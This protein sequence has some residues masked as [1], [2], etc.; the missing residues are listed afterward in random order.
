MAFAEIVKSINPAAWI[1][2]T[3][4]HVVLFVSLVVATPF[5]MLQ[6]YMQDA[7]HLL[8]VLKV[9]LWGL[10]IVVVPAI[11]IISII[12]ALVLFRRYLTKIRLLGALVAFLMI[13]SA[14]QVADLYLNLKFYDIQQNWHYF[15]YA[16]FAYILYRDL[17]PRGVSWDKLIRYAYIIALSASIFDEAF[18]MEMS[19]RIFD[20]S[21]IAKDGWGV[22][23]GLLLIC[24]WVDKSFFLSPEYRRLR[25]SRLRDYFVQP[26]SLLLLLMVM[27]FLLIF[28]SSLLTE[29]EYWKH[30]VA[31]TLLTSAVLLLLVHISQFKWGK[32]SLIVVLSTLI[33]IQLG[34][35]IKYRDQGIT[36][37][38]A[39]LT[40]YKGIP[41]PFFDVMFYPDGRIRLVDKKRS[42]NQTDRLFLLRQESDI[43]L[44]GSGP[45]GEGGEGFP[46]KADSQFLYNPISKKGT[47][48]IVL[49]NEEACEVFN[50]LIREKK[51]VLFILHNPC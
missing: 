1:N 42:F 12:A 46:K 40:I 41:L 24:F 13:A 9:E 29:L 15:A 51:N 27:T 6:V 3:R 19:N 37:T 32:M 35:F 22:L 25:H 38:Q 45:D 21:D 2:S 28:Y 10:E 31:F 4:V 36:H 48:V 33:L 14:Q 11:A 47:Q 34:S 5:M 39:G 23:M 20:I 16:L 44:I 49:K 26:M 43:V 8:S 18:Q 17:G 50:R 7:V 30:I